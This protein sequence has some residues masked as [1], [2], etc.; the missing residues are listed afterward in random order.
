VTTSR[1]ARALSLL[2][3]G[4]LLPS[5]AT[6]TI[7]GNDPHSREV[8]ER[9]PH[10]RCVWL[11]LSWEGVE[12]P[13]EE[14]VEAAVTGFLGGELRAATCV[15]RT[16]DRRPQAD[17]LVEASLRKARETQSRINWDNSQVEFL[18]GVLPVVLPLA[19]LTWWL[20]D[21]YVDTGLEV[22]IR[23]Q[24]L[25]TDT[26]DSVREVSRRVPEL[27]TSLRDRQPFLSWSTLGGLF[28]PACVFGAVQDE[29]LQQTMQDR[30]RFA[31][32]VEI[33]R[34]L[35]GQDDQEVLSDFHIC[36]Y[37]DR[38]LLTY[39][40]APDL[41]HVSVRLGGSGPGDG[42]LV[43]S[44][45]LQLDDSRA[46]QGR[47]QRILLP[48]LDEAEVRSRVLRIEAVDRTGKRYHYSLMQTAR[49]GTPA[50]RNR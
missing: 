39:E 22:A 13:Q 48:R 33:A 11:D 14:E 50:G 24:R 9:L 36:P 41:W 46:A 25:E 1:A 40:A 32:A 8:K 31:I 19:G 23:V 17:L 4:A 49:D 43:H 18:F 15:W 5:C 44:S 29:H 35:K 10:P 3:V 20:P 21:V 42:T 47:R 7:L 28:V 45:L 37:G 38:D 12:A 26:E 27:V 16:Q 2:A 30:L 34:E 6:I